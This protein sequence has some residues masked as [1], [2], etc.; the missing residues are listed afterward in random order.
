MMN[1]C[2]KVIILYQR[3]NIIRIANCF[4]KIDGNIIRKHNLALS[5][6][7]YCRTTSAKIRKTDYKV[8][9][10][11]F[12]VTIPFTSFFENSYCALHEGGNAIQYGKNISIILFA[13]HQ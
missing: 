5:H 3:I 2:A 13:W 11:F 9:D 7:F 12:V 8:S 6:L 4:C 1:I 10:G